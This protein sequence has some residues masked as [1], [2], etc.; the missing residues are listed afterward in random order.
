MYAVYG[1]LAV[2]GTMGPWYLLLL[3]GHCV[4]LYVASLL[5]QPWLCLGFGLASLASFKMDP[6]ISWQVCSR[7]VK[8]CGGP[9]T[10]YFLQSPCLSHT[11]FPLFS[12]L[13]VCPAHKVATCTTAGA[14]H[15]ISRSITLLR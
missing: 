13:W 10:S 5:G 12:S 14:M 8:G 11:P 9:L 15:P 2:V 4:G 6:L 1:V 7:V 3:L